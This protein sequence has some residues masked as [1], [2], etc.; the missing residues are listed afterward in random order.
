[1]R[2][3]PRPPA[4]LDLG[5]KAGG[6]ER[7]IFRATAG[8]AGLDAHRGPLAGTWGPLAGAWGMAGNLATLRLST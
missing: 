7:P 5:K 3:V 2:C 6:W 4:G 8:S 1:M